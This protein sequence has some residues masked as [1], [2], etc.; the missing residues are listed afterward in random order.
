MPATLHGSLYFLS[1]VTFSRVI[2]AWQGKVQVSGLPWLVR[3]AVGSRQWGLLGLGNAVQ[4]NVEFEGW[5][6]ILKRIRSYT[7]QL[8][9]RTASKPTVRDL[10]QSKRATSGDPAGVETPGPVLRD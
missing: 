7:Q 8:S 5:S 3:D 9:S 6:G 4:C 2:G 10:P 1:N